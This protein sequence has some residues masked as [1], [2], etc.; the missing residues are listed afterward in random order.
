MN[1]KIAV[2][3][4]DGIGPEIVAESVKVL[5]AV[6]SRFGH[7]FEYIYGKI[8]A[9]AIDDCSNPY[10]DDTHKLCM[11]SDAILFGAIGDPKYDNNPAAKI[12]PEQGLLKMRKSLGLYA[13]IRPVEIYSKLIDRSPLKESVVKDVNLI[14]VR[15]LTGGIYFG[16]P[17]GR[18]EDGKR[19]FDT[20]LYSDSEI[21]RISR[22]AFKMARKRKGK[23]TL[24]DKANVLA[25]SRLWR[26]VVSTLHKNEFSDVQLDFLFV[27]NAAMQL[28][29]DP[30]RFDV[31][32]TENLFGDILSDQ[33]SV[34]TGSIG[35]LPSSS[36]GVHT[37]LF[38]PIH[39][40]FPQGAGKN[41]ANPIATILSAAMM[42]ESAFD[43]SIEAL[44]IKKG[45]EEAI[46]NGILT[47]EL[48][49]EAK[50]YTT[51]NIGDYISDYVAKN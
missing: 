4:G 46:N 16:E 10:P 40:S 2:L 42:L 22:V 31:I 11:E 12:R 15:E 30:G 9:V 44:S 37:P 14:V 18:S 3:P 19:A 6:E 1:K 39:G 21:E 49:K 25:T 45:C 7:K 33:A 48:A 20:S 8:G 34:L 27:D 35:L 38:E 26:E 28:V 32:L 41:I 29:T 50:S 51:S 13:N 36:I 47:P 23:V 17:R 24:V 43:M 5:K